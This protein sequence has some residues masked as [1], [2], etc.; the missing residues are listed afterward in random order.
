MRIRRLIC[1]NL[2]ILFLLPAFVLAGTATVEWQ[3]NSEIDLKEYRLYH[4]T[5]S[6]SYGTFVPVGKATSYT[7][8]N[9]AEGT[10]H[11]FAVSAVDMDNN[12]SGYSAEANKYV[13]ASDAQPP[14]MTIVSPSSS[15]TYSTSSSSITITGT[16]SDNVGVKQVSWS[17]DRAGSGLATG[18][19][20]WSIPAIGLSDGVNK[21]TVAGRD[22]A[23]NEG[24]TVIAVTYTVPAPADQE[25]PKVVITLPTAAGT[26]STS[27]SSTTLAGTASD[28]VGVKQ[29]S[30]SNDRGGSGLATGTTG[31]S[32]K[33]IRLSYGQNTITVTA[34]DAAGNQGKVVLLVTYRRR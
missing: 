32:V 17:N 7:I 34:K 26:Y 8:D 10:T 9:L 28:N 13:S 23:G 19:T 4:G 12:E 15:G 29:V 18:T 3:A 22:A 11:Y 2:S 25:A 27:S 5:A 30:W 1:L 24:T 20:N 21:I 14:Q 16:A 6:R 33:R 31:W